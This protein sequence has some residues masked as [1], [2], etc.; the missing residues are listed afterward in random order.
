MGRQTSGEIRLVP[1]AYR[2]RRRKLPIR[3]DRRG[4]RN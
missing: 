3:G 1:E 4:C 2:M